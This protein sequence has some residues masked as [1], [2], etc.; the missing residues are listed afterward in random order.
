MKTEDLILFTTVAEY[1]SQS[2]AARALGIPVSKVSRHIAQLEQHLGTRLL[3]RTTRSLSLT[4][5]GIE[6]LERS[7]IILAEV[8]ALEM[9][10]G[11][12]QAQPQ[13]LVT[14]AAPLDFISHACS[15]ALPLL[16]QRYPALRL[17]FISY[18]SRQNPMDVQADLVLFIG[19][20]SP[21]DSSMVG[22]RLNTIKRSFVAS[23]DFVASNPDLVHP[24]QLTQYPCL[25]T[26]K[27]AQPSDNWLWLHNDKLHSVEVNGPF[28]SES[29]ELCIAGAINSQGVA[30]VPPVMCL[31]HLKSGRL[32]LLFDGR[33]A[34]D[35][36]MWGLY[37]SR[38]YLPHRVRV[39]LDFFQQK[40]AKIQQEAE[41]IK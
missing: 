22:Q 35:V 20:D 41:L 33:Y 18:Q 38:Y 2:A 17:K 34:T 3:E 26:A 21:P 27:G 16:C 15:E 12:L 28:E 31:E 10:V 13:G 24:K 25:L 37:S 9:S 1:K 11:Q 19:H 5:A 8:E 6:L 29:I 36:S 32:K 30:W 7:K 40:L 14:V 39:V 23:P 4:D